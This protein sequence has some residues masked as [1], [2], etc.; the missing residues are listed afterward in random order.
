MFFNKSPDNL[1]A[2]FFNVPQGATMTLTI[3]LFMGQMEPAGLLQTFV[4]AYCAGVMLTIFLRIPTFGNWVAKL[5]RC[6]NPK[7]SYLV[8]NLASGALAGVFMNFFMTFMVLGPV[9][10]FMSAFF[11]TR[12]IS[13]VV[14]AISSTVWVGLAGVVVGK[15]YGKKNG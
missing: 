2:A 15:V 6:E 13:M 9:P 5:F 14:S 4:C 7:I 8:S 11:H 10:Y 1:F 12:P 3:S